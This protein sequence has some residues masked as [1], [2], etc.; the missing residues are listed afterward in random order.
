MF[1]PKIKIPAELYERLKK[2]AEKAG[3]SSVDEFII[4]ALDK[5]A[6]ATPSADT[7]D[8][9]LKKQLQGLGYID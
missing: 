9:A 2:T 3:Y 5:A 8:E 4:H 6:P 7:D 1:E